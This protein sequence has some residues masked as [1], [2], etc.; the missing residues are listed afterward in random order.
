MGPGESEVQG[1]GDQVLVILS[2]LR[3][4]G[5]ALLSLNKSKSPLRILQEHLKDLEPFLT[6]E[7]DD[8]VK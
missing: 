1:Q 6:T 2:I 8:A 7:S 5:E 3:C 4:S